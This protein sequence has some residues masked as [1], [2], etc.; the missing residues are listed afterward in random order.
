MLVGF[1][2]DCQSLFDTLG[3]RS[4]ECFA[5]PPGLYACMFLA[6]VLVTDTKGQIT[7]KQ[8][9]KQYYYVNFPSYPE[10]PNDFLDRLIPCWK[11]L[12]DADTVHCVDPKDKEKAKKLFHVNCV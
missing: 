3:Y 8:N 2:G 6:A 5:C 11:K 12:H 4:S 9:S 1:L 7:D 10:N